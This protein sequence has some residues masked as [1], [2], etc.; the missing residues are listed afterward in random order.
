PHQTI[1]NEA[2]VE[3]NADSQATASDSVTTA[4]PCGSS[5]LADEVV[6]TVEIRAFCGAI[7]VGPAFEIRA[8]GQLT[9]VAGDEIILRDGFFVS[10][11]G[12]LVVT[13]DP[14]LS[15]N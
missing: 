14:A 9:L 6:E 11:G 12:K 13:V 7:E 2:T 1:I 5:P 3:D 8:P 15:D 10:S 4:A